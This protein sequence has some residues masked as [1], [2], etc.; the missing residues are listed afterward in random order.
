MSKELI[1]AMVKMKDREAVEI[2]RNML[3]GG[4]EPMKIMEACKEA[5]GIVGERFEK[6]E[7]FLP[8]LMMAG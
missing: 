8:E 1:D 2:A 6:G 5:M 4:E 3:D 7:F